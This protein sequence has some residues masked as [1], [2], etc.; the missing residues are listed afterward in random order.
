MIAQDC[1]VV[2]AAKKLA[3]PKDWHA[4]IDGGFRPFDVSVEQYG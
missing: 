3:M 4:A 2:I 1:A